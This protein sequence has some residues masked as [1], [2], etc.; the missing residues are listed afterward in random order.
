[1]KIYAAIRRG[2]GKEQ[3]EDVVIIQNTVVCDDTAELVFSKNGAICVA[4]GVGGNEG[5]YIAASYVAK[6]LM[7][8]TSP[9][10]DLNE[11]SVRNH[12]MDINKNL[13]QEGTILGLPNMATTLTGL[14]CL[15]NQ[16]Y[17]I[18]IGNTRAYVL[19]GQYLKQMTV[20]HTVYQRLLNMGRIDQATECRR[21]EITNCLGGKN[22]LL[23]VDLYVAPCQDF[24]E[25][26]LTSDG[27]HDYISLEEMEHLLTIKG[28]SGLDKCESILKAASSAKST[29]DMSVVIIINREE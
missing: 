19:Q 15:E 8:F 12:I 21:N 1:M 10:A 7:S 26:L 16:K 2:I 14:V 3:C 6:Q 5:G 23:A 13:I 4:D 24:C 11:E 22:T 18:H 20:D 28:L 25:M 17:L 9:F 27:V 29:D